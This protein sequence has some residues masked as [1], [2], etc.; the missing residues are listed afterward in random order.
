MGG[1][2][3]LGFVNVPIIDLGRTDAPAQIDL[4]CRTAGFFA[5]TGHGIDRSER[6]GVIDAARRFFALAPDEKSQVSL[7][8]GGGAWRGWFPLGDELTSGVPDRKEGYYFGRQITADQRPL[9]GPNI[10]PGSVPELQPAVNRWM[11]S[12]EILGTQ[13][14]RAMATGL[15][16]DATYF[17]TT[18]TAEPTSLF[19]IFTYP[20]HVTDG[21]APDRWGVAEHTDYGLLTL[22]AHDGTPGLEVKVAN[23]W[24]AVPHDPELIICNL[25]DMLD[26]LT[27]GSYRSTPH[28]VRNHSA[29]DRISLPFFLDPSWDARIQPLPASRTASADERERWDHADLRDFDGTYGDWLVSKVSKVFPDLARSFWGGPEGPGGGASP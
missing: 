5:L 11:A 22:L 21:D 26:R 7:L 9:H 29:G 13:V 23:H 18:L 15:G 20:P 14:L 16:L 25:G 27:G 4:A 28:R 24:T 10:W 6:T 3:T 19:R 2:P 12:M 8:A 1:E 17:A